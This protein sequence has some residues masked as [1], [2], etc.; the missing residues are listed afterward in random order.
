M[1]SITLKFS[2][3]KERDTKNVLRYIG[4]CSNGIDYG[5]T[6]VS[7]HPKLGSCKK[8]ECVDYVDK[9]YAK[10]SG[11]IKDDLV[12]TEQ[13]W[14]KFKT[15]FEYYLNLIFP[16]DFHFEEVIQVNPSVINSNPIFF[17]E[18]TFMYGL[19][20]NE[21]QKL[22]V[23]FHELLHFI[24]KHFLQNFNLDKKAENIMLESFNFIILNQEFFKKIL[25]PEEERSYAHI[26]KNKLELERLYNESE[27]LFDFSDKLKRMRCL[28]DI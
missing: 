4:S 21:K 19:N 15:Q 16:E 5:K 9:Y 23:I 7:L 2:L 18:K 13:L 3:N 8:N 10:N 14:L 25:S 11:K 28:L 26:R 20:L 24:Y 27:N 12:K 17:E 1:I 22:L 6:I